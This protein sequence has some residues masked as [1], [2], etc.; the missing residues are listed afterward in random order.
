MKGRPAGKSVVQRRRGIAAVELAL[1]LPFLLILGLGAI[2]VCN[3]MYVRA[4]MYSAA[5]EAARYATRPTTASTL[6]ASSPQAASSLVTNYC[7]TLLG[8]LGVSGGTVTLQ[9]LDDTTSQPKSITAAGPMDQ[10]TVSV[11]APLNQNYLTSYV[12]NTSI[13]L[14]ASATL[15][16][17]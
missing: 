11:A 8:Q 6:A 15:I 12:I 5:Y 2:E 13:T 3:I 4:R 10:V 16:V 7:T 1:C 14:N 17:E 9:V